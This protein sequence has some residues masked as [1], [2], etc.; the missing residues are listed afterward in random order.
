MA[1]EILF[2]GISTCEASTGL[3]SARCLAKK[4]QCELLLEIVFGHDLQQVVQECM[5]VIGKSGSILDLVFLDGHSEEC[6][7]LVEAGISNHKS[8]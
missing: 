1:L 7:V 3:S 5:R 4:T 2:L 6:E 8:V